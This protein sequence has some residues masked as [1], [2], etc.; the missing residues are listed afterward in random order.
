MHLDEPVNQTLYKYVG[1]GGLDILEALRLKI[2]SAVGFNDP[3]EFAPLFKKPTVS[4]VQ[5]TNKMNL[6]PGVLERFS[7]LFVS[8]WGEEEIRWLRATHWKFVDEN[9]G[10]ICLSD[11]ND[12]LLMWA[13]Y[14]DHHRGLCI[15]FDF[16]QF[17]IPIEIHPVNYSDD[18]PELDTDS[19][20]LGLQQVDNA[21][22]I[23][24]TKSSHW[25]YE[26][27]FRAFFGNLGKNRPAF[28]FLPPRAIHRVI[29]GLRTE[30]DVEQSVR[31]LL[32]MP[33]LDHVAL[34]QAQADTRRFG[35]QLVLVPR[36]Y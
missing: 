31:R 35:I 2:S 32:S 36:P 1:V 15:G 30:S 33:K 9:F 22:R 11:K 8:N 19:C 17:A 34:F 12:D 27:E 25:Q 6:P 10:V 13:H 21:R 18:R 26:C 5:Q 24:Y 7:N 4:V 28:L 14:A 3:F 29:L 16:S 20:F 23:V